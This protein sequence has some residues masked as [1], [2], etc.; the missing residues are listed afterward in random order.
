MVVIEC[1]RNDC[2]YVTGDVADCIAAAL[3]GAHAT[4]HTGNGGGNNNNARP[5]PMERP[6]LTANC[7][8][9]EWEVFVAKWRSFKAA[10]NVTGNKV[11]HQLLGCLE[12]DISSLVYSEH[13]SPEA[14]DEMALLEL[15]KRVAVKPENIWVT[16]EKFH[17]MK[18]D[19]GEPVTSFAARLKG[20]ARLCGFQIT[21]KCNKAGCNQMNTVDFTDTVVMGDLVRGLGDPEIKAVV[22]GEVEQRTELKG[23]IELVQAKE[24]GRLSTSVQARVSG[25]LSRSKTPR[26]CQNCGGEHEKGATWKEH[27][28]AKNKKCNDC[29]KVGHFAICCRKTKSAKKKVM[30]LKLSSD[31]RMRRSLV[32]LS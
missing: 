1:P 9:A 8:K 18:Q 12:T 22:L 27:C 17:S 13:A 28:P 14:L 16:R 20:Q 19:V 24:Y 2:E 29:R 4:I 23:L 15:I 7:P 10:T 6:K 25:V 30:L 26:A 5:P 21:T 3:L 32:A 31:Q 11:V